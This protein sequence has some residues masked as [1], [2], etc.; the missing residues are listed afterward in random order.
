MPNNVGLS[1]ISQTSGYAFLF[2]LCHSVL[3][4]FIVLSI[5]ASISDL[6]LS[7]LLVYSHS[8]SP[9]KRVTHAICSCLPNNGWRDKSPCKTRWGH[10][11]G[12]QHSPMP[13]VAV[14]PIGSSTGQ[15]PFRATLE[16]LTADHVLVI[17]CSSETIR[18]PTRN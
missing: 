6:P 12:G 15:C 18:M 10:L 1:L 4:F 14:P 11:V 2:H 9:L 8:S 3:P 16:H 5:T 17:I 13:P 7:M